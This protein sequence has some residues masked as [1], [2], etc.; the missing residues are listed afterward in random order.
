M[1]SL[2]IYKNM[3]PTHLGD[4][5]QIDECQ[6]HDSFR[7]NLEIYRFRTDSLVIARHSLRLILN[8][9]TDLVKVGERFLRMEK[10]APFIALNCAYWNVCCVMK[11]KICDSLS[12]M[13]LPSF[14]VLCSLSSSGV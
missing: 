1:K 3:F 11:C 7:V 4:T 8:L 12:A 5:R 6:V 10:F 13:C 14:D 2:E 9:T